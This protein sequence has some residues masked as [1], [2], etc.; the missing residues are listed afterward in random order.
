[1]RGH[2]ATPEALQ[3]AFYLGRLNP[4]KPNPWK[5]RT[6]GASRHAAF[7]RGRQAARG[8]TES[9]ESRLVQ[10]ARLSGSAT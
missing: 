4:D 1:M 2:P 8:A 5:P 3:F 6:S 7:E 9:D 10:P